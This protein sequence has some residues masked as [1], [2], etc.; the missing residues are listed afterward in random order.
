MRKP[1]LKTPPPPEH[2]YLDLDA[3]LF[4]AAS[5]GEQV[6]YT[7]VTPEGEEVARFNS[8]SAYKNWLEISEDFGMD[9]EFGFTGDLSTLTRQVDYE[10]KPFEESKKAFDY[11]IEKWVKKSGCK[12]WTGYVSK[13]SGEK[14]FRYDVATLKAYK[15]SRKDLRKPLHLE[16]LR[17]YA[18]SHPKIKTARGSV[19]VDDVVCALAQRKGWRGCVVGVDKD[20]RG[21]HNTYIL[22]PEEMEGPEFSSNKIVGKLWKSE[23]GKV[24]GYGTLFWIYQAI[25]GDPVDT[26]PG[27]KKI[28]PEGAYSRLEP[29]S[30]VS[31][32]Y[33]PDL[34]N[35]LCNTFLG[36]FGATHDYQHCTTG[37]DVT[38]TYKELAIEMSRLVY[39]KKSQKDECFWIPLIE[40][41]EIENND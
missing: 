24:M 15:D 20:A 17:Q 13:A 38:A 18:A 5:A 16:A 30:G 11:I 33:L 28:G 8:A 23:K 2:A 22:I 39:M 7:G 19:E 12:D 10:P 31:A 6:V 35:T 32:D 40:E 25:G 14:N 4:A 41:H 34:I 26:I 3:P 36:A 29:F 21:V 9:M 37:E 27:C 1:I